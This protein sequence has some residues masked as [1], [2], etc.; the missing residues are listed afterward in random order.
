MSVQV[1]HHQ[2]DLFCFWIID[3][4][5]FPDLVR[6]IDPSPSF[7]G[8]HVPP[9]SRW[10]CK[11]KDAAG[12]VADIFTILA[13]RPSRLHRDRVSGL[14]KKL[15]WLFIHADDQIQSAV[16]LLVQIQN[17]FHAGDEGR[18]DP[19]ECTSIYGDGVLVR[20]LKAVPRPQLSAMILASTSPV[21]LGATGGVSRFFLPSAAC[22]PCSEYCRRIVWTVLV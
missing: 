19:A 13:L 16:L 3:L 5:Q 12:S 18:S 2:P 8:C 1:I 7:T 10:V 20:F 4:Q 11:D 9:A 15:V 21:I 6:P 22:S 17:I 14:A